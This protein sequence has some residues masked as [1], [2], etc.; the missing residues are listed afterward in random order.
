VFERFTD[1]ARRTI[2]SAQDEARVLGH[3][4]IGTEHLLLGLLH[5]RDGV[6]AKALESLDISLGA[7]RFEV[8]AMIGT[9]SKEP[10]LHLPFTP[11]ARTALE[12][13]LREALQLGHEYIGTE[14]ILLGLIREGE[15]VAAQA[16]VKLGAD[17]SRVRQK[18]VQLLAGYPGGQPADPA[19]VAS[20][21]RSGFAADLSE[22]RDY[23]TRGLERA[24]LSADPIMQFLRW[25]ADASMAG[26]EEPNAMTLATV[27][28]HGQPDARI[29]LLRGVDER[30]F[31]WYTNRN[32]RKGRELA[33]NPRAALV[34][35]WLSLHRQVRVLGSVSTIDDAESDEYFASRPRDS[36][37]GAWAS[38]Q[39][40]ELAD[41]SVLDAAV[42]ELEKRFEGGE[43]PRPPHW[44]G[45]RLEHETVEL[46]QGRANRLHDRFRYTRQGDLWTIARLSP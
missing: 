36:Q 9:G 10:S 22:R 35:V 15:G 1:R 7:V 37:I 42:S 24:E 28:A 26:L 44:G 43:V 8:K 30:G 2:V 17:L 32:S 19:N 16:L 29:V 40:E 12:L 4:W 38:A 39:S 31:T 33:A 25:F 20:R 34:F 27:D 21:R 23:E 46:W 18:V 6:A 11:R 5:E 45:Y 14:H 3:D 13:S 41:R